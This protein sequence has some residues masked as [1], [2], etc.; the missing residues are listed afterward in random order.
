[1]AK[2]VELVVGLVVLGMLAAVAIP[3]LTGPDTETR[4]AAVKSMGGALRSAANRAHGV[5]LAQACMNGSVIVID[6]QTIT[7]VNGYPTGAT[8]GKLIPRVDGFT[9]N[10][11]GDTFVRIDS[12]TDQCWVRYAEALAGQQPIIS[13]QA[14]TIT[15]AASEVLVNNALRQQC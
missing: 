7:F 1:M 10:A 8:V 14:G 11:A 5:C 6:G 9:L 12:H 3:R 2:R 13:Y 15:N 4:V